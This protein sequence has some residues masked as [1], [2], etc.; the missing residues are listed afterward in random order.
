MFFQSRADI[1]EMRKEDRARSAGKAYGVSL[2]ASIN[3][4]IS[5]GCRKECSAGGIAG[6]DTSGS[7]LPVTC[8]TAVQIKAHAFLIY[9]GEQSAAS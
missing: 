5:P 2:T 7:F 1:S 9:L 8:K 6:M 3:G 4:L